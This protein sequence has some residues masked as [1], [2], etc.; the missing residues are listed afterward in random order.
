M[1]EAQGGQRTSSG[2]ALVRGH[3][4]K[5]G[6][7]NTL[8]GAKD[9]SFTETLPNSRFWKEQSFVVS[10]HSKQRLINTKGGWAKDLYELSHKVLR[11]NLRATRT[12][13]CL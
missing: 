6:R 4:Q 13:H 11:I 7:R 1:S 10:V 8:R 5:S 9:T 3:A 12:L 2:G